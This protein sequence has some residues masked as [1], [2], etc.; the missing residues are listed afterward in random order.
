MIVGVD[1]ERGLRPR[2]SEDRGAG[3]CGEER[4]WYDL[5][6]RLPH[7]KT[8]ESG[9]S[10]EQGQVHHPARCNRLH[11]HLAHRLHHAQPDGVQLTNPHQVSAVIERDLSFV[12]V[13]QKKTKIHSH[14]TFYCIGPCI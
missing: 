14:N 3:S 13:Q 11:R 12:Q 8:R 4:R 9:E 6:G 5:H 1:G 2:G 10:L 7:A